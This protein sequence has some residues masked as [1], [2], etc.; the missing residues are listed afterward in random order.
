MFSNSASVP[1][2]GQITIGANGSLLAVGAQNTVTDWLNSTKIATGSSGSIAFASNSSENI[3]FS[4]FNTLGLSALGSATYSGTITPGTNGYRFGGDGGTLTV[5]SVLALNGS[6]GLTK[7][8]PGALVLSGNNTYTGTTTVNGGA[9]TVQNNQTAA[10]G[11][12]QMS[13]ISVSSSISFASGAT[14]NVIGGKSINV[15]VST[16]ST[17]GAT[18]NSDAAVTNAG[19]L[20]LQRNT[21]LNVTSGTWAQSGNLTVGGNGGYRGAMNVS[22]GIFTYTGASAAIGYDGSATGNITISGAGE[23]RFQGAGNVLLGRGTTNASSN[24]IAGEIAVNSGGT[25]TTQ[26]KFTLNVEEGRIALGG[27]TIKLSNDLPDFSDNLPLVITTAN[28]TTF[29]TN[30]FST[31]ID[32]A[33]S[34]AAA[35]AFTKTGGGTL[36]LSNA[37]NAYTGVTNVT[38]G[39]LQLSGVLSGT[40]GL[41]LSG[42]G[43][44]AL[45]ADNILNNAATL[46]FAGGAFSTNGFDETASTLTLGIGASTLNFGS[47][48]SIL[49][50]ANSSAL[51]WT[52]T[53]NILNW[54]GDV[55]GGGLD[56]LF[57]GTTAAGLSA[58][59]VAAIQ[60]VDPAGLPS[61]TYS[62]QMLPN[63]E[64]VAVPEPSSIAILAGGFG[65][66]LGVRRRRETQ[67]T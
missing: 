38:G 57:F 23:A 37:N 11:G 13:N 21:T 51:A 43:E 47:G 49:T 42:G 67:S 64:L 61:G 6:L 50:L 7:A 20:N 12:Y 63:G 60:F 59:Q 10:T 4:G 39:T 52:G 14:I 65:C 1:S 2:T 30:D 54:S 41:N 9:L 27:G 17:V 53:L 33:I 48:S 66:L 34:S 8:G 44:F 3:N 19:S 22:G 25:L 32:D 55:A 58:G 26:Q 29:N 62:A 28:A 5:S 35:G 15:G 45:G 56:Q 46:N 31:T 16:S 36:I 40:T 18:V 24:N